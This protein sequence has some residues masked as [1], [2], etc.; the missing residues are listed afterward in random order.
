MT[1]QKVYLPIPFREQQSGVVLGV[2]LLGFWTLLG[3]LGFSLIEGWSFFDA[4]YM[5]I[6]T[7]STVGFG[8]THPLS[9]EGRVF[10]SFL[11]VTGIGT[12]IYTFTR[13]GQVLLEGELQGV[14]GRKRMNKDVANLKDHY[15]VCGLGRL[16]KPVAKDLAKEGY[17]LCIVEHDLDRETELQA[18]QQLYVLGDAT[19][20]SV[21]MAAGIER[22]KVVLALLGSDADNLYLTI[23]AKELNPEVSVIA[24]ASDE[25]AERRLERSG[26]DRVISLYK[27]AYARILDA[28]TKPTVGEFLE[29]VTHREHLQLRME[30]ITICQ[31]SPLQDL[32]LARSELR[33]RYGVVVVAIKQASGEMAF[34]PEASTKLAANDTLVVIGKTSDLKRLET[35]CKGS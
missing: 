21:L 9:S 14:L 3:T 28:A 34:N 18:A 23:T 4:F 31:G 24:R 11:I 1:G 15:I 13:L 32:T 20:E 19:D 29:L 6:I 16:G 22:A 10:A 8:E 27:T 33:S 2:I 12:A 26:A 17:P 35:V 25:K 7:I 30:E 5:T